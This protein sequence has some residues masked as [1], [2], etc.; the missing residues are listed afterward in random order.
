M[1]TPTVSVIIPT[2]NEERDIEGCLEAIAAQD[3]DNIVEI[4]VVDGRSTDETRVLASRHAA[5]RIL[6]NPARLQACALN[7]GLRAARGELIA[8]VDGHCRISPD[9]VSRCVDALESTGA[10]MVGGPMRPVGDGWVSRGVAEAM[11]SRAGA[12]PAAFHVGGSGWVDTVY[13]G[14]YRREDA[15]LVG[16]YAE[17]VGVNED[18]EFAMRMR[19]LGGIWLDPAIRSTYTPRDS[20]RAVARQFRRYGASRAQTLRRHP[21]SLSPRQLAAPALLAGLLTSR[22]R[23]VAVV[24]G[25]FVLSQALRVARRDAL[26]AAS[27]MVAVP[28]M[29]ISWAFGFYTGL[30]SPKYAPA[31]AVDVEQL[32]PAQGAP[33]NGSTHAFAPR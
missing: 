6:D 15:L 22:R 10:A 18:A 23:T 1:T 21:S 7:I 31:P 19:P 28:T 17:D 13:L 27:F 4:L 8:R 24:Y 11:G 33:M 5:V 29:H 2:F 9:Y 14:A 32:S 20:I 25:A 12:G 3:Y 16:G 30:A 26:S